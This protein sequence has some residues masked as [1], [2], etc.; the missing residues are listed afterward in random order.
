[1]ARW[2]IYGKNG[3]AKAVIDSLELHDEWMA[4][5]FVTLSITSHEPIEFAIGDYLDYRG[6]RYTINYDPSVLKKARKDTYGEGFVYENIKFVAVQDEIVRCDFTDIVLSDNNIH[7]TMLPTFPFY[8]ETVDDLLDRIQAN[9][10]ELYPGDWIIISPMLERDR[11][12]GLC[13]GRESAFVEAYNEYIG[14]GSFSYDKT[15]VSITVDNINCWEALK[16]VNDSFGLNFIVRGRVVIVGTV[17]MYTSRNFRYGKGNGL[18]ELEKI[19]DSEQ[20]IITRMRGYGAET[21]LPT[22][23]YATLDTLP[24]AVVDSIRES[25]TE[26]KPFIDFN[27]DL[28]GTAYWT[29]Q[30]YL[31]LGNWTDEQLIS[32]TGYIVTMK[33]GG[34]TAIGRVFTGY[35]LVRIYMEYSDTDDRTP[36]GVPVSVR[37]WDS[38]VGFINAVHEGVHVYFLDRVKVGAFDKD[39]LEGE[40]ALPDNMAIN[41]LMLPGFPTKSLAQWVE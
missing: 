38:A 17:G 32:G 18:Y 30:A 27:I 28:T 39:H 35:G 31:K 23:F 14:G 16:H 33:C 3:A 41:R 2:T 4:E 5:C 21:N 7:Y 6:E 11:Q 13:V 9:L 20:R 1:M 12:R 34:Y 40:S 24:F 29:Y 19:S 8:C 10:E 22:R 26:D 36:A 25:T 37:D 15:G